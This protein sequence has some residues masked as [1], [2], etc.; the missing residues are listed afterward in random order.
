MNGFQNEHNLLKVSGKQT[1]MLN[2]IKKKANDNEPMTHILNVKVVNQVD[3]DIGDNLRRIVCKCINDKNVHLIDKSGNDLYINWQSCK[4]TTS[5]YYYAD[6]MYNDRVTQKYTGQLLQRVLA[7]FQRKYP[8]VV[9]GNMGL[10]F[11]IMKPLEN[12]IPLAPL[13]IVVPPVN[14]TN[15]ELVADESVITLG[16]R[17]REGKKTAL[18]E[19][20]VAKKRKV[21]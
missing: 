1:E 13:I 6:S 5:A 20:K 18:G 11:L 14:P 16:K 17:K 19:G 3:N 15:I 4:S 21:N 12:S 8:T 10:S 2:V 7:E 9:W